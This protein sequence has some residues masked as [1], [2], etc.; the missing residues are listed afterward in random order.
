MRLLYVIE[1]ISTTG[2]LERILVE[3]MNAL[4]AD[5]AFEVT[6]LTVWHDEMPPAFPLDSRI[7]HDCLDVPCPTSAVGMALA[8]P[9][10]VRRF[11]KYV[12][13][14]GPDVVVHF[15]AVGAMLAAFSS[16][17]GRTIFEAH[18][19]RQHSNHAWLYPLMERRVDTVVC[20]TKGDAA[21]YRRA[22]HVE[23]IPNFTSINGEWRMENGEWRTCLFVGRLCPEKNP[24]RL[25][26]LWQIISEKNA[27]L[28]L[29]IYGEGEMAPSM[30]Q[31]IV[32][33]G[34]AESVTMHGAATDMARVYAEHD[35]LLLTSQT[36]GLPMV[37]IEAMRCGLPAVSLDC[38]YGPADVIEHGVTGYVVPQSDDEGFVQSVLKLMKDDALR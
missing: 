20:L 35:L 32:R 14:L 9:R 36:E 5:P 26:R 37:L 11:N 3:K 4:S 2:G 23:V 19:A 16:W 30:R 6:L 25:L 29:D 21:N 31:E 8:M 13:R 38:P 17:K 24:L 27:H 28:H 34:I 18:S 22:K 15:R 33:L 7:K 10:V 12:H 1:H